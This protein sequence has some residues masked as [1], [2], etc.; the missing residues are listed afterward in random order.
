MTLW[1]LLRTHL[2][3]HRRAIVLVVVLQTAQTAAL[4]LLPA[5]SAT[6]I[7]EG[8]LVGDRDTIWRIGA[9][10]LAI[11]FV[12]V[13]LAGAAMWFAAQAAMGFG[14]DVRR[15]IFQAVT[16]F[17][18]RE[19]GHF[20]APSLITRITNDVQQ[21][22][23]L[24]VMVAT[25]M[26]AA[27]LTMVIGTVLAVREDA[28][29]STLLLVAV[30]LEIAVLGSI[31]ARMFPAFQQMQ[32]RIDRVNSVLREQ[33]TGV[34]VVRAFTREPEES[35]RFD[36]AN[37]ELTSTALR[38]ARLFAA[39]FPTVTLIVNVSSIAAIWIGGDRVAAGQT[40]IGSLVAF[41]SYLV[42]ILFAVVMATF[43]VSMIPR[44]SVAAER[45]LEVVETE[46][47]VRP[48]TEPVLDLAEP[49]TVELRDVG[50]RYPG[51]KHA[52]LEGVSVRVEPGET[53]AVIGSTGAGKTTMLSLV[54]RLMDST[55]G[56]VRVGG[57]DVRRLAP[58]ALW[59]S[60]G[61][62]PQRSYLFAGTIES[63][64]RFARPDAS[65]AQLWEALEIAQ[66]AGFVQSLADGLDSPVAQGGTNFSGGQRQRLA[67]ARALIARP[68]VFLF[69]DS[70]SALDLATEARLRAALEPV[71]RDAA[72]IVVAQR[73]ST[74][75]TAD[76]I[77]VLE[78]GETV[79]LGRHDE[80]IASCPT[81][82]EIVASQD[83]G[84][85]A[86]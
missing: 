41:L 32:E 51:A 45:I 12:Q 83:A 72:V 52:V 76:Q 50:F 42:Q 60:I 79:G 24:V 8:V 65:D 62:V 81:Y 34:R 80:L 30:P 18:A 40:Q 39:A 16:E 47:S 48:P 13:V 20:G 17:S 5:L 21:V 35:R 29:L 15:D 9:L 59:R 70:F 38:S 2:A 75:R 53:L 19:I 63:N 26:I 44:A 4:L 73:I 49:G 6:L 36:T 54:C 43:M 46:P 33:I 82:A 22:Q 14:R 68:S 84:P 77:L 64:L 67:I 10:M 27:P 71:V 3:P 58:E 31:V 56:A 86:A 78:D 23:L 28:G 69:D 55:A 1:R 7:D 74:I 11:A 57:V 85:V 25:M 61:Y 37:A 66:A